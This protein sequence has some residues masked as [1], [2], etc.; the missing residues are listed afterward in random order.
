MVSVILINRQDSKD[1]LVATDTSWVKE[2]LASAVTVGL[3]GA[4]AHAHAY[5]GYPVHG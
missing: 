5:L 3:H 4:V 1:A 2:A